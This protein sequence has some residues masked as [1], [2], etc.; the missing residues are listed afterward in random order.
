MK[1]TQILINKPVYLELQIIELSKTIMY[2]FWY[3]H[4]KPK[5][6]K[7]AKLCC[8]D[9]VSF[10]IHIKTDDIYKENAEDAETRF[11]TSKYELEK[12]LPKGKNKKVIGLMKNKLHGKIMIEFIGLRAK[13]YNYLIDDRSENKKAKG[14]N[15][16]VIKRKRKFKDYSNCLEPTGL[17]TKQPI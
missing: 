2:D 1:K 6:G 17:E 9:T 10:I 12:S 13:T 14:T 11:D 4:M 5:Y 8:T 7:K 15:M 3:D 16:C